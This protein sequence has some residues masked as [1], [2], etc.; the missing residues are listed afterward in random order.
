[1]VKI[2]AV[3]RRPRDNF[4]ASNLRFIP[5]ADIIERR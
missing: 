4:T 2:E 3:M 1:M 5:K